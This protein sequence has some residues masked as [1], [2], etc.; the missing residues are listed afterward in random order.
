MQPPGPR[1]WLVKSEPASF[2]WR[3]QLAHGVEPWTGVRNHQARA[4][5]MAMRLGERVFF[6]HSVSERKIVGVVEVVRTAYPDPTAPDG[7]WVAVDL[8]ALAS[9]PRPVPL[10]AMK[11]VPELAGLRL[12]RQP[13][14]SVL[15]LTAAEWRCLCRLGGLPE[16]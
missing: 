9:L 14:L 16:T 4:A 6:Y 3:E 1:F 11:A 2:G 13:R 5:L 7:P 12:L 10:A 15:E 8:R